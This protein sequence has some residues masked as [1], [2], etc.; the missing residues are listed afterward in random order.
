MVSFSLAE[1]T[2]HLERLFQPGMTWDNYGNGGW[3]IDH[4]IPVRA[5]NFTS[6]RDIDFQRCW[7]LENLQP[8]WEKDNFTKGGR[9]DGSFQPALALE[10][11]L[12]TKKKGRRK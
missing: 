3:N 12:G 11:K 5:F 4:I 7:A 1:L 10:V 8:L 6:Y 2:A 9:F